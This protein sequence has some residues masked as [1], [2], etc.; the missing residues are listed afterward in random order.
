M[1]GPGP[2][3]IAGAVQGGMS[4]GSQ[5]IAGYQSKRNMQRTIAANKAEAELAYQRDLEMWQRQNEYN[6]PQAQMQRLIDAGL[7]PHLMY[8]SGSVGNTG[9]NPPSYHPAPVNYNQKPMVTL[10][11]IPQAI[12]MYQ[13]F[14]MRQAQIDN[15]RAQTDNIAMRT[16]SE[17]FRQTLMDIQGKKT[18]LDRDI[19]LNLW[20]YQANIKQSEAERGQIGVDQAMQMLRN[21][22][23]DE[24]IKGLDAQSKR[25]GFDET[26][27]RTEKIQAEKLYQ[28]MQND[29]MRM[30]VTTSDN[31]L[32]RVLVRMMNE[33]GIT[34]YEQLKNA[35]SELMPKFLK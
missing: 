28:D 4:I 33:A 12:S 3:I 31:A 21:M 32:V 9:S 18:E 34:D 27:A 14:S 2:A 13:D 17:S 23:Q 16:L 15:V 7:N 5:L 6:S 8:G 35:V 30:G 1:A 26:R 22:K 11:G 19:A 25:L 10:E 29:W 20:P 24:I